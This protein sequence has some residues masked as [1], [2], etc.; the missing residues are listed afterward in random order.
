MT[1]IDHAADATTTELS[2]ELIFQIASA[3]TAEQRRYATDLLRYY[4]RRVEIE[5]Y[6]RGQQSMD[7]PRLP[8]P[9]LA[10]DDG[11]PAIQPGDDAVV[12]LIPPV[13]WQ[14]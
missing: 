3:T 8:P 12:S 11:A 10:I 14:D 7:I 13:R 6:R 1:I 4:V 2:E 5:A 9:Q